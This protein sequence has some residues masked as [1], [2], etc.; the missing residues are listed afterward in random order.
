MESTPGGPFPASFQHRKATGVPWVAIAAVLQP[1]LRL[2][3]GLTAKPGACCTSLRRRR[4]PPR[5]TLA[6][7]R[8]C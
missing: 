4:C 7:T 2:S 6:S 8:E 3:S 5:L 1:K